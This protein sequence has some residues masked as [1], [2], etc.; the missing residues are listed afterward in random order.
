MGNA[1]VKEPINSYCSATLESCRQLMQ[2]L[3]SPDCNIQ[4]VALTSLKAITAD[5]TLSKVLI[6]DKISSPATSILCP[7]IVRL[8]HT[9]SQMPLINISL[10][11][12]I[13]LNLQDKLEEDSIKMM[14]KATGLWQILDRIE[15]CVHD[16]AFE[17]FMKVRLLKLGSYMTE[18]GTIPDISQRKKWQNS[19]NGAAQYSREEK[20]LSQSKFKTQPALIE[21]NIGKWVKIMTM[22]E[23]LV[24]WGK[25]ASADKHLGKFTIKESVQV[26][27]RAIGRNWDFKHRKSLQIFFFNDCRTVEVVSKESVDKMLAP[28][29][30]DDE[31]DKKKKEN[32]NLLTPWTKKTNDDEKK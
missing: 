32:D 6:G 18:N 15:D 2:L 12:D 21:A 24:F 14:Y 20:C 3:R 16:A 25:L 29:D 13:L 7:A 4:R 10:G 17:I 8:L 27:K 9:M 30:D 22:L 26:V 23:G 11:L 1:L 31:D 5:P 19:S 28:W